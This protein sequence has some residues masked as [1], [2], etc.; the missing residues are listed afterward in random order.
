LQ[1]LC[2]SLDNAIS[3]VNRKLGVHNWG[4]HIWFLGDWETNKYWDY[5]LLWYD[6]IYCGRTVPTLLG[7]YWKQGQW[8]PQNC[9]YLSTKPA[10]ITQVK[11]VSCL[12][13]LLN[14]VHTSFSPSPTCPDIQVIV[15]K[16]G[17]IWRRMYLIWKH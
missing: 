6:I 14:I 17:W 15:I 9:R 1:H 2:G 4:D 7:K 12:S 3:I 11:N 8:V 16:N 5:G 13:G 10:S